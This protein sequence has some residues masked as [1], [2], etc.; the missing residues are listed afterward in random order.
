MKAGKIVLIVVGA[1]FLGLLLLIGSCVGGLLLFTK[2]PVDVADKL[3]QLCG[4]NKIHEC[5]QLTGR[6]FQENTD[7]ASFTASV[8]R[9]G[10]DKAVKASWSS[11]KVEND[12][13]FVSGTVELSDG[14]SIE[15]E[16]QSLHRGGRWEIMG[17]VHEK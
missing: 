9:D 6:E 11:R 10:I 17:I 16:V 14:K 12:K 15:L 1:S 5:Y 13:G 2:G 3:V 8:R 7:E 4:A